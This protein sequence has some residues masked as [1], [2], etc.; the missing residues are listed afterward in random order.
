L[1]KQIKKDISENKVPN[2]QPLRDLAHKNL[3]VARNLR[4]KDAQK[5]LNNIMKEYDADII[6]KY[7]DYLESCAILL[8]PKVA[9]EVYSS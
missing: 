9:Y 2:F 7:I 5:I 6:E 3:G 4:I 8:K 1:V